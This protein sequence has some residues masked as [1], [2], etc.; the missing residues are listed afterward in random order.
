MF[1]NKQFNGVL[2]CLRTEI[3][4]G[5]LYAK[6]ENKLLI[7]DETAPSLND[8]IKSKG[9]GL[10]VIESKNDISD[11]IIVNYAF[12]V[13][14]DIKFTNDLQ[15]SEVKD[16]KDK[17]VKWKRDE[18]YGAY[19]SILNIINELMKN[20]KVDNYSYLTFF[21]D[22]VPYGAFFNSIIPC[23]H[24][25]RS[26]TI[27][28][29]IFN[30]IFFEQYEHY[31][32]SAIVFSPNPPDLATYTKM[33]SEKVC[34]TLKNFN[35]LVKKLLD[36]NATVEAFDS[37]V[38][39]YPY[40]ILHICS[41]GGETD[42]YYVVQEYT[43]REGIRHTVEYE[44]VVGFSPDD[45]EYVNVVSKKIF[46]YFDGHIW[47]SE[48]LENQKYAQYVYSD[49]FKALC[50]KEERSEIT[51]K[52]IDYLIESSC[53]I[54]CY[55]NIHQGQFHVLAS[56]NYPFVFNNTCNS[57]GEFETQLIAGGC[58]AYIG[59][60]W[61]VGNE[62]ATSSSHIFYSNAFDSNIINSFNSMVNAID[63]DKYKDIYLFCGLHFASLKRPSNLSNEKIIKELAV[64][65]S[66][67]L[68][69][70][71]N[72]KS[73]EVLRNTIK[74]IQFLCKE[75]TPYHDIPGIIE[76]IVRSVKVCYYLKSKLV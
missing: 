40:D 32:G 51:R 39:Y 59:T 29:F 49:M 37:Y 50:D 35:L 56:Q 58:R 75:L 8:F 64:S 47:K 52:K 72:K 70:S 23:S 16:L 54:K 21:T 48:E 31:F 68:E 9:E 7:V 22:G 69:K 19:L 13:N 60:L 11:I 44:E 46:R 15:P 57:W 36:K 3:S 27:D 1:L 63:S 67:W 10:I 45:G 28:L 43:D 26:I 42:G 20:I 24:V 55:D 2:Y 38:G 14:A 4:R 17:F 18:S 12:S 41:H 5:L 30:N 25:L 71:S 73:Q 61:N 76:L 53:Y 6:N 65:L 62:T 66:R 33:E 34:N 74:I